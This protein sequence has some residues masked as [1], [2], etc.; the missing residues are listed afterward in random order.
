MSEAWFRISAEITKAV[1]LFV[2]AIAIWQARRLASDI[3][4]NVDKFAEDKDKAAHHTVARKAMADFYL[5]FA[6]LVI[7][8]AGI[9][10]LLEGQLFA[11]S[12]IAVLA[13]LGV[14]IA[15]DIKK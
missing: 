1:S 6:S 8:I 15:L 14:K 5:A 11:V 13:G 10:H 3:I 4:S 2:L 12:L 7:L 9:F